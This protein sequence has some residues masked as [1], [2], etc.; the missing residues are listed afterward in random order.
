MQ[1]KWVPAPCKFFVNTISSP[2]CVLATWSVTAGASVTDLFSLQHDD[3]SQCPDVVLFRCGNFGMLL[4]NARN[5]LVDVSGMNL[6]FYS[7][8]RVLC[9]VHSLW[10]F[11][12]FCCRVRCV[13]F[14][15]NAEYVAFGLGRTD[16]KL[17][18]STIN[19]NP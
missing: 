3:D 16:Y 11:G 15:C 12:Q 2:A 4:V 1:V 13:F 7:G 6:I 9:P 17:A 14:F 8:I 19:R 5:K 10:H 18:H